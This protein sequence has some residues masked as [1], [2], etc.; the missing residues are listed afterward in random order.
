MIVIIARPLHPCS[1][2]SWENVPLDW[3]YRREN[4]CWLHSA[5]VWDFNPLRVI[6]L[7][8]SLIVC[9]QI[10][11]LLKANKSYTSCFSR[12]TELVEFVYCTHTLLRQYNLK[13]TAF[14]LNGD[15]ICASSSHVMLSNK[16]L[17][18][19]YV[20][21]TALIAT[22]LSPLLQRF[23]G[24][25]RFLCL[26]AI[27]YFSARP[28]FL[29]GGLALFNIKIKMS[30]LHPHTSPW[31]VTLLYV[32]WTMKNSKKKQCFHCISDISPFRISSENTSCKCKKLFDMYCW[33]AEF[34]F[35]FF[36]KLV[37]FHSQS[38][39]VNVNTHIFNN[40]IPP[41]HCKKSVSTNM[42]NI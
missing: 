23:L 42:P 27:H 26:R 9:H 5:S 28:P 32:M 19:I 17:V 10:S 38:F 20:A 39:K 3:N 24:S 2:S 25:F 30:Q 16:A 6:K 34:V 29:L 35:L 22:E 18:A 41:R 1:R 13:M 33:H 37:Y 8:F 40:L 11:N 31:H 15:Q 7:I 4:S 12:Q 21:T 36:F 14:P